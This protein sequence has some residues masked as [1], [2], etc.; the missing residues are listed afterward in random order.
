MTHLFVL[1]LIPVLVLGAAFLILKGSITGKEF[2]LAIGVSL[3]TLLIGWQL[4]KWGALRS[5]EH[6]NGR[7]TKKVD[8]TQ[9]CC[10]CHDVCD[11]RDK[12]GKCT[13]S[14][15]VCSHSIDYNWSLE[16]SVGEIDIE[17]CSG[18]DDPPSIWR[19]ASVGDPVSVNHGYDNYLLADPDSLFVHETMGKFTGAIPSYPEVYNK[20]KVDHAISQGVSVPIGWQEELRE[21]NADLGAPNQVD[22]AVLLTNIADPTYAQAVEAQWLYGPKNSIT[23]VMGV[24][25]NDIAWVRVITFSRVELLK[26][27]LRDQLQQMKLNDPNVMKVIRREIQN[28]FHRTAMADFEYLARTAKPKGWW[29]FGLY[30]F[31]I[32]V[33]IGLVY[34]THTK[35]IFGDEGFQRAFGRQKN[36]F[37][38]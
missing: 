26:V 13:S 29:L 9:H 2:A 25:G 28:G 8:G 22:V 32:A 1:L 37:K 38:I 3:I 19:N 35:D 17:D 33:S 31:E 10:H 27:R 12:D 11:A 21:I 7:I 24:A 5:D 16:T 34:W 15:E 6:L 23:I 36:P 14:H 18:S 4:A 20:F 30:L